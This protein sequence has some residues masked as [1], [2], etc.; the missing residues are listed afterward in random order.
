MQFMAYR[1]GQT[2][3]FKVVANNEDEAAFRAAMA[4]FLQPEQIDLLANPM[5]SSVVSTKGILPL[6]G[7]HVVVPIDC[8]LG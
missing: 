2:E 1:S 6:D 4:R 7:Y 8:V 3:A 5:G